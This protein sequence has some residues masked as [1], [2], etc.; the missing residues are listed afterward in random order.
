MK[1]C[2]RL[3][4][5]DWLASREYVNEES[6]KNIRW[7]ERFKEH[8]RTPHIG[9]N[10]KEVGGPK[11]HPKDRAAGALGASNPFPAYIYF[12]DERPANLPGV[13]RHRCKRFTF[14]NGRKARPPLAGDREIHRHA[15]KAV[16][17]RRTGRLHLEAGSVAN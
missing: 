14:E 11:M 17:V 12:L 3:H 7:F 13:C 1:C 9:V 8:R 16:R 2:L 15:Q 5:L 6:I 4:A 10:G